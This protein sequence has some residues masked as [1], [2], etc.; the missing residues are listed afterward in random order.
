MSHRLSTAFGS[1]PVTRL[2]MQLAFD[3]VR[4]RHLEREIAVD[5]I[6]D[7]S[8]EVNYPVVPDDFL[9]DPRFLFA[10]HDQIV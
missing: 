4:S 7:G 3:L 10:E 8:V 1:T 9:L 6:D 5:R 2:D